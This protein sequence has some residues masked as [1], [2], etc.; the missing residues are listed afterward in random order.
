MNNPEI[1]LNRTYDESNKQKCTLLMIACLNEFED[2]VQI[3]LN[4]SGV[5][6]EVLNDIQLEE[7]D[8]SLLMYENVTVLWAAVAIDN[9]NIVKLLIE[10]GAKINHTT[11]TNSTAFRCACSNGN[12]NIARYLNKNGANI[13]I[14]K[15]HN[16]TNLILTVYNEDLKMV[17]YLVDELGCDVNES[18]DNGCSPLYFAVDRGSFELVQFLLNHGARN[19]RS[20]HDQMSPLLLAAEKRRI[21]LVDAISP[22]C[23]LL[24]KIEAHELLGS[25]FA[26]GEHGS[27]NLEQSFEY[28][29]RALELRFQHNLP[30]VLRLSTVEVFDNRQ[31]CQTIDE[32]KKLQLNDNHMYIEALLVRERLLGSTNTKYRRSLQYHGA[33][34]ADNAEH[35]RGIEFWLYELNLRRQYSLSIDMEDLRQWASM[36]SDMLRNSLSIPIVSWQTIITVVIEELEHHTKDFDYNL[37]TLLFLITIVSQMLSKSMISYDDRK[38]FYR[39]IHSIIQRQYVTQTYRSSL[40]HLSLSN[41]TSAN[42]YFI[43]FICKYPSLHT[44]HLLIQCGAD[45]NARDAVQNTPLH[46]F[47]SQSTIVDNTIIQYLFDAGSHADYVNA[48]RETPIDIATNSN[49]KQFIRTKTKL[50]LKCL[51]ARL[52]QKNSILCH[53]KI[54]NSLINFV[55]KH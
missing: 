47:V 20:N 25:A 6:L 37:H 21:D 55:E 27:Y 15:I 42:D 1:Y 38:L 28:F 34:L 19:F 44:V 26:C 49:I 22:Q 35:Y 16:E 12:M 40:L 53:G 39:H 17:T 30:K 54:A 14:A 3:L 5:D 46:I 43:D 50:S 52:I 10:H 18:M 2:I 9:V 51:C 48:L 33:A 4:Y 41:H 31:E 8:E 11:K 45:V 32:L 13:H 36:F 23:S 7:R 24:E 29:Y